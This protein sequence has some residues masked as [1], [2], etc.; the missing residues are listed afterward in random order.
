MRKL[1]CIHVHVVVEGND[2]RWLGFQR[3]EFSDRIV[4]SFFG[5]V[6]AFKIAHIDFHLLLR[7]RMLVS[8]HSFLAGCEIDRPIDHGNL[9]V[10]PAV[11]PVH[12][13]DGAFVYITVHLVNIRLVRNPVKKYHWNPGIFNLLE[14]ANFIRVF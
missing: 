1:C 4:C 6:S 7:K 8:F 12:H 2:G 14:V 13:V 3:E 10:A 5:E 11:Q 9:S